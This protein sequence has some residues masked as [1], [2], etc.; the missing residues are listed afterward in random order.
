MSTVYVLLDTEDSSVVL[1]THDME[2]AEEERIE[3]ARELAEQLDEGAEY[4]RHYADQ[5]VI[6]KSL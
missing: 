5:F 3:L 2:E 4:W 6:M 1:V